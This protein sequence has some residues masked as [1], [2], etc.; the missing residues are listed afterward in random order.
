MAKNFLSAKIN[1]YMVPC[2]DNILLCVCVKL[3]HVQSNSV[4]SQ[5]KSYKTGGLLTWNVL[6]RG[7]IKYYGHTK[8]VFNK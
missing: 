8:L 7:K 4:W 5:G 2:V 3:L 1:C 6:K